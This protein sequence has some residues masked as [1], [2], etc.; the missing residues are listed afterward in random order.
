MIQ[1]VQS[2]FLFLAAILLLLVN[3][4]SLWNATITGPEGVIPYSESLVTIKYL[5]M[6]LPL[7]AMIVLLLINI[8]LFNN[9]K[10][11]I[12]LCVM[13]ILGIVTFLGI[14]F[15]KINKLR[16]SLEGKIFDD[17]YQLTY[18]L[19]I[20]AILLVILAILYIRKDN[21]LVKSLDR[22]R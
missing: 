14:S 18:M 9:R 15:S 3:Y 19:P 5:V 21:N 11:Q 10:L 20:A 12:R 4:L 8:F 7:N 1:R 16:Q 22:I 17:A 13:A 2:V 6:L